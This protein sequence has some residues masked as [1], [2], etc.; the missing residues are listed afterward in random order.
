[1]TSHSFHI[2]VMGIGFTIDTP[3]KVAHYGISSVI[4]LVD[5]ILIEK[6]REFYCKQMNMPFVAVGN[7]IDDFR[8]KRIMLY[9]NL[10]DETVQKKCIEL[11]VSPFEKGSKITKYFEMLSDDSPLRQVYYQML[12]TEDNET[13]DKLQNWLRGNV[14]A[15]SIDVNIMTKLDKINFRGKEEQTFEYNDA[16][17]ALRG[18]ALSTLNSSIVLSAGIN[19][20]LYSYMATFE[21][22]YPDENGNLRKKI[23]VKVND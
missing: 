14:I 22:F 20:Q 6:M 18:F 19:T 3:I 23:I 17:A 21:D 11:K 12:Q 13:R 9:L 7:D 16:C 5:D 1:M 10:V 8:A 15:G 2:P 4:S